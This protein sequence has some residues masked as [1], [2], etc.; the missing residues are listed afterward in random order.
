MELTFAFDA[1]GDGKTPLLT[2]AGFAASAANWHQ[3]S[4]EWN[5]RLKQDGIEYFHATDLDE[6]W[7]PFRH[8]K[9]NPKREMLK[10]S[11]REDLMDIIHRNVF[12][13]FGCT[14]VNNLFGQMSAELRR[15]FALCAY[16]LAGRTCEK[17]AREWGVKTFGGGKP[18][19]VE[20][21]FES[22]DKGYGNLQK[23]LGQG[24]FKPIF[25]PKKDEAKD[26]VVQKGFTPLQASDWLASEVNRAAKQMLEGRV[27]GT[28]DLSWAMREFT[29]HPTGFLGTYT[30]DNLKQLEE[31]A[32]LQ[33]K[34]IAWSKTA[35]LDKKNANSKGRTS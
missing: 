11:L 7:G 31:G 25:R 17:R 15:E 34:I 1:A 22:G 26:G 23:N 27:E 35:G 2:V 18:V 10:Q 16:S 28:P 32:I 19:P 8:W 24:R 12:E 3:F 21:V 33:K 9:G 5:D 30:S 4:T 20:L 6:F 14:I 13:K 29:R